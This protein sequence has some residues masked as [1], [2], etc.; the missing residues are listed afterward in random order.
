M[1]MMMQIQNFIPRHAFQMR[2]SRFTSQMKLR[3]CLVCGGVLQFRL[4]NCGTPQKKGH[5][6]TSQIFRLL[7][8]TYVFTVI[9]AYNTYF[10]CNT[11]ITFV[12]YVQ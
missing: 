5:L 6:N 2:G 8:L 7:I 4:V 1:M 11:V 9:A 10:F 3:L 12:V